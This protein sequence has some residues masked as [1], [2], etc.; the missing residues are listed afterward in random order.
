MKKTESLRVLYDSY[1]TAAAL[2]EAKGVKAHGQ[3]NVYRRSDFTCK[4]PMYRR[5]FYKISLVIGSGKLYYADRG[6]EINGQALILSNP[7]IPYTWEATSEKQ[8]GYFCVFTDDF[9]QQNKTKSLGESPLFR[10]GGDFVLHLQPAQVSFVNDI[11]EKMLDEI[12]SDYSHKYDVLRNYVDL[13]IHEALKLQP[14]VGYFK[15]SSASNRIASLFLELIERQ[16]PVDA[17]HILKIK[18]P[19]DF[20]ERLSI[21]VNH[22][23]RAVK[24]TTQKTT[25]E[26]IAERIVS[27]AKSLLTHTDWNISE[28]A[29]ALGF[30]Y[31][32]NFNNFFKKQTGLAPRDLRSV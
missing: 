13:L 8:E 22:L 23:N 19:H 11:F 7:N 6:I 17:E 10:L 15:H 20:A 4:L 24:E 29:Y 21:H 14:A 5:D 28:I 12:D 31:P 27:E 16:F 3:I 25:T 30:E 18:T 1:F 26:H 32:A 2:P 9:I